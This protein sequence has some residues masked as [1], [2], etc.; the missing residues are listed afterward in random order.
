MSTDLIQG[1]S[2]CA[3]R[4]IYLVVFK[5]NSITSNYKITLFLLQ[6]TCTCVQLNTCIS[7]WQ[8]YGSPQTSAFHPK[9]INTISMYVGEIDND[10]FR[11]EITDFA[12]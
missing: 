10:L 2:G 6:H 11:K 3:I 12:V 5:K 4:F 7:N 1:C 8:L 9:T